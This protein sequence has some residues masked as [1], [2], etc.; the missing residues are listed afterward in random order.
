M[1]ILVWQKAVTERKLITQAQDYF[2][3]IILYCILQCTILADEFMEEFFDL[4]VEYKAEQV[5]LK[6]SLLVTGYTHKFNVEVDGQ[7]VIFEPDEEKIYRA[8]INYEDIK[9]NKNIDGELLKAIFYVIIAVES[10]LNQTPSYE[11][12]RSLEVPEV[13]ISSQP[14]LESKNI[15]SEVFVSGYNIHPFGTEDDNKLADLEIPLP[16]EARDFVR[17]FDSLCAIPGVRP[18]FPEFEFEISIPEEIIA[19]VNIDEV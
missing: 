1:L 15:F 6:T 18:I 11:N 9:M 8:V 12:I 2:F 7:N 19:W 10:F 5:M 3:H 14:F 4:P 17:L 13:M 16:K